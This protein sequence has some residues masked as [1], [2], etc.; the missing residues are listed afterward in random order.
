[1]PIQLPDPD[2]TS[3][4]GTPLCTCSHCGQLKPLEEFGLRKRD[5]IRPGEDLYHKQSWCVACR[6]PNG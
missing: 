1:M 2:A 6:R 3:P 5:D 4:E